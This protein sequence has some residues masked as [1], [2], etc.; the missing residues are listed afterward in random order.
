MINYQFFP[1]SHGVTPEIKVV[2]NCFKKMES[3]IEVK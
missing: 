3:Q 2:I 1:W